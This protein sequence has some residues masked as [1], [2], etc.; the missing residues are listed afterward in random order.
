MDYIIYDY[1]LDVKAYWQFIHY[2]LWT[3]YKIG[4][5]VIAMYYQTVGAVLSSP[6]VEKGIYRYQDFFNIST[7]K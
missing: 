6:S 7:S 5:F 1:S 3:T 2:Y 4:A